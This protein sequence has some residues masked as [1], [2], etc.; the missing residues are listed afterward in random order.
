MSAN[1]TACVKTPMTKL[2]TQCYV[3]CVFDWLENL[4]RF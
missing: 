4:V 2:I 3:K 1:G